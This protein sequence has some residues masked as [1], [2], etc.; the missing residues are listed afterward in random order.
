MLEVVYG[1]TKNPIVTSQLV[2]LIGGLNV[3]GTLYIGYPV[4]SSADESIFVE[5]LLICDQFGLVVFSIGNGLGQPPNDEFWNRV[6]EKQDTL[7]FAIQTNLGRHLALRR[8]RDLAI[9]IN[10]ISFFPDDLQVPAGRDLLVAGPGTLSTVLGGCDQFDPQYQRHLNAA[11][12]RVTTI[13]P[14]KKR[15]NVARGDSR[16]AVMREIE[17]EIANLDQW[18]KR[19]AIETPAGPQRIRGLA[20]SGKT[21]VLALK[22]AY[23]HAQ[24]PDWNI[25]LTFHTRSLYQQ[26]T[27]LVRRFSFE[28]SND[29]P[30]WDRLKIIH[31]W[32]SAAKPGVYA[33]MA[34]SVGMP[35]RNYLYA[36][37]TY[38]M[39]EAF[40][41]IC[42]ELLSATKG[43]RVEPIYDAVLIDEAQ[44]LPWS[45]FHLVYDFTSDAKR[46]IWAYDELQNLSDTSMPPLEE[47]FGKDS[48]G[49]PRIQLTH[50]P[51]EPRQ[52]ITLPV[53]Y[54]NTPWAL[55]LAHALGFGI[56]RDGGLV[57]LFDD[58]GLWSEIGYTVLDGSPNLGQQVSLKRSENSYPA[59]FSAHLNR[60]DAI[61][62]QKLDDDDHQAE[63]VAAEI[64]RNLTDDELEPDDILIILPNV[65]TAKRRAA[66]VMN[67]LARRGIQSHIAGVSTS[68]DEIFA[69]GSVALANIYR[70]KGNEAPMVY[71]LHSQYCVGGHELIKVRNILFTA[72]TR[73]RA[74]V[75]LYGIGPDMDELIAEVDAIRTHDYR[76]DFT[77]PTAPELA[78]L[79]MIHRER[80]AS[81]RAKIDRVQKTLQEFVEAVEAGDMAIENLPPEM[82]EA[83]KKFFKPGEGK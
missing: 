58:P 70:A 74:W 68:A 33:L 30:N 5:A 16:G 61:V 19:A 47:L 2:D 79:R 17:R 4:L 44:D 69:K 77:V 63:T 49:R 46:I 11:L 7:Y 75:R 36:K 72:I 22:A 50:T 1:Q 14:S 25:A 29:E 9:P 80:T 8:R 27:D 26:L 55:T 15:A 81:E 83:F 10:V 52:D 34:E 64:Q 28:H 38:G 82:R 51:G 60:E 78:R 67:S 65:L 3:D 54:R 13:K 35:P 32:G 48:A 53:C 23:L 18:Q 42:R 59:Y 39:N 12:Q 24:N 41:G 40:H 6:Q 37:T 76:L 31:A 57:Q 56:Y 43:R 20:G 73:S 71:V 45:F 21:V 66:A 62:C